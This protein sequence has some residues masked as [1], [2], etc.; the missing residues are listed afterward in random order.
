MPLAFNATLSVDY[1][2][3]VL[4]ELRKEVGDLVHRFRRTDHDRQEGKVFVG[5]RPEPPL[6]RAALLADIAAAACGA[7]GRATGE[8]PVPVLGP[9]PGH[10]MEQI[11]CAAGVGVEQRLAQAVCGMGM[12]PGHLSTALAAP[13]LSAEALEASEAA[14][15]S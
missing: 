11:A 7:C 2:P 3:H 15:A 14:K 4:L 8:V 12:C 9:A 6:C 10:S 13:D 1:I 5:A